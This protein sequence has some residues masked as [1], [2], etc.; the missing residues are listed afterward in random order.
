MDVFLGDLLA[1]S[2]SAG[3]LHLGGSC[4][5][6]DPLCWC[7]VL[8]SVQ[9]TVCFVKEFILYINLSNFLLEKK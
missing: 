3:L 8:V 7:A 6:W 1:C 2:S 4:F 9:L 5:V